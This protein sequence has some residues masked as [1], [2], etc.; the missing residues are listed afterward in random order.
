MKRWIYSI[1]IVIIVSILIVGCSVVGAV[2]LPTDLNDN[3][4]SVK[5]NPLDESVDKPEYIEE[6]DKLQES[7]Q[8][9]E[10]DKSQ[11]INNNTD[12]SKDDEVKTEDDP[13]PIESKIHYSGDGD[14]K[15]VAIT[16]DDGPESKYTPQIL[17]ILD[18][19]NIKAT[20]FVIGQNAEKYPDALKSIHEKGHEIGSH[21]WSHKYF[22]KL[23]QSAVEEEILKTQNII[24][25]ITGEYRPIFRPPYGA[26][27]KQG[28]ELVSSLGYN[29]VNWSVDTRDWAG[30]SEEQMMNYVKQQLK[31]GG[32][33]LMHNA[34]NP[35]SIENTIRFLPTM[36][37]W[38]TEQGYEFVTVSE[39]L[40]L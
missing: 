14:K 3:E 7:D 19:Y 25:D 15:L 11:E 5:E 27:E 1:C 30:T 10:N 18:E 32:I 8:S 24:E 20:F 9:E 36:I 6:N 26:L 40:N 13:K 37:E 39:I 4:Q 34:G 12:S 23:S 28:R 2:N 33:V 16:F 21:S 29:I 22:P 31:P 35:K 17:D 38:I